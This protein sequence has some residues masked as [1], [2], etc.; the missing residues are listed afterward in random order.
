MNLKISNDFVQKKLKM[1]ALEK[2]FNNPVSQVLTSKRQKEL[3]DLQ[4]K[5]DLPIG[6]LM[7]TTERNKAK[8]AKRFR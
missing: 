2:L 6:N 4:N 8:R 3:A 1:S 5:V 7:T